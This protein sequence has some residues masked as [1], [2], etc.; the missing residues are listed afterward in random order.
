VVVV[1]AVV[2]LAAAVTAAAVVVTR[3][4]RGTESQRVCV[5]TQKSEPR[6][7]CECSTR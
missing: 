5:N 1:V 3:T 7:E 4:L 6:M 2:D